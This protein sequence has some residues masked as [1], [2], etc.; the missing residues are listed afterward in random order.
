MLDQW[1]E[2]RAACLAYTSEFIRLP[3]FGSN[4]AALASA[5]QQPLLLLCAQ[6]TPQDASILGRWQVDVG[7]STP[8]LKPLTSSLTIKDGAKL[9]LAWWRRT[10]EGDVYLSGP[11]LR[12]E[13]AR[14]LPIVERPWRLIF[15]D[16]PPIAA[17]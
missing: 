2:T 6:P 7:R 4:G 9:L 3:A 15:R 12:G 13:L 1:R 10:P 11:W 17:T 5:L 8:Q 16:R 14:N